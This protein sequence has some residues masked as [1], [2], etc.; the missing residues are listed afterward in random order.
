MA[1]T[2]I[3]LG[4]LV[5]ISQLDDVVVRIFSRSMCVCH[6]AFLDCMCVEVSFGSSR[7]SWFARSVS[8]VFNDAIDVSRLCSERGL[9]VLGRLVVWLG[10]W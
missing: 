7:C 6:D 1:P 9:C 4:W 8:V 2:L 10:I 3:R 5:I